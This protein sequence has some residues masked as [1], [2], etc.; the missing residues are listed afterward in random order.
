MADDPKHGD[1]GQAD[2]KKGGGNSD[3]KHGD[4]SKAK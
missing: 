4:N 2:T 1:N 3:P